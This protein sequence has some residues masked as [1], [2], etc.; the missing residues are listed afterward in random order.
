MKRLDFISEKG[1]RVDFLKSHFSPKHGTVDVLVGLQFGDEGKGKNIDV[2][3]PL[4][5]IIARWQGGP[6]SGHSITIGEMKMIFHTLPSG[7][8]RGG[9]NY[10][11]NKVTINPIILAKEIHELLDK[12]GI[13]ARERLFISE[14]AIFILPTHVWEDKVSEIALGDKK[15]GSTKN[16]ICQA[17]TRDTARDG[18]RVGDMLKPNFN[19]LV[20]DKIRKDI[21]RVR[22]QYESINNPELQKALLFDYT[23]IKKWKK[24]LDNIR[25]EMIVSSMWIIDQLEKGKTV[26]AEGA[27]ATW[28]DLTFGNYPYVTSSNTVSGSVCVGLGIP[29]QKINRVYGVTKAYDTRVGEGPFTEVPEKIGKEIAK[30]GDE[31]GSTTGRPRKI[32]WL[33]LKTLKDACRLNGVTHIIVNK[34][35]VLNNLQFSVLE[36]DGN[37]TS[38]SDTQITSEGECNQYAHIFLNYLADW[39]EKNTDA[40]LA[41]IS[42]G[43]EREEFILNR[44]THRLIGQNS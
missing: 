11:G 10:I 1:H 26:L 42:T 40:H 12:T 17:Y 3:A 22:K 28:L 2:L 18:L 34:F 7:S 23:E 14:L 15:I 24:S 8:A 21:E 25:E 35:D 6:N 9:L 43:P 36:H 41:M 31:F 32:G 19:E 4:Y 29:P 20:D 30:I 37:T 16:G 27:Q 38:F 13:D 5:D 44:R 39:I 33:N